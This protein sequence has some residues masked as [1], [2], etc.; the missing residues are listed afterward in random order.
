ME[1][2]QIIDTFCK[3]RFWAEKH[4]NAIK[5]AQKSRI[6]KEHKHNSPQDVSIQ[7]R[8]RIHEVKKGEIIPQGKKSLRD[9]G[10]C[11]A[12]GRHWV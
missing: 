5:R 8:Q 6:N 4:E 2:S 7:D 12:V 1:S 9:F 3:I 11:G 10:Y